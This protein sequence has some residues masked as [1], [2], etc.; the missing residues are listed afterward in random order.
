VV[1][2]PKDLE[3]EDEMHLGIGRLIAE[4]A[5][6]EYFFFAVLECLI[7]AE[8]MRHCEA[9]WLS[10]RS[11]RA[12]YKMVLASCEVNQLE[13]GLL[14]DVREC[15]AVFRG[16][17]RLRN[18]YAHARFVRED[19]QTAQFE[20]FELTDGGHEDDPVRSTIKLVNWDSIKELRETVNRAERL[21][22]RM[23][24]VAHRL[25]DHTGAQHVERLHYRAQTIWA[26]N[27]GI[28]SVHID[29]FT[30]CAHAS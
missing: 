30:H 7:G 1:N 17:A 10:H 28:T 11:A 2:W 15:A 27:N 26:P 12:R 3:H 14:A 9:I 8:E 23:V 21:Y 29:V 6:C 20:G 4:T 18:F 5:S 19:A 22:E 25:R 24:H 16:V 13:P